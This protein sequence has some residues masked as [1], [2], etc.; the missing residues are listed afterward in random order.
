MLE[1]EDKQ[2]FK[3]AIRSSE[4]ERDYL[5]WGVVAALAAIAWYRGEDVFASSVFEMIV[6][7]LLAITCREAL[8]IRVLLLKAEF[9]EALR[10]GEVF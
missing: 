8:N 10:H 1:A 3:T 9:R 2:R 6:V 5:P 4:R 7:L